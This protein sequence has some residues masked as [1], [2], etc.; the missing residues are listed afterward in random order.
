MQEAVPETTG[1]TAEASNTGGCPRNAGQTLVGSNE[2]GC[3]LNDWMRR[4]PE[5]G[6][7]PEWQGGGWESAG[8]Q[9]VDK[10]QGVMVVSGL[11]GA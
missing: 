6:G 8:L 2:S 7:C 11:A 4:A 9:L 5:T 10:G 1:Q 3:P